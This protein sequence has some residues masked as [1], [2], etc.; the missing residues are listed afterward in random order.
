[1]PNPT[2]ERNASVKIAFGTENIDMMISCPKMF[3]M[4]S[5]K[6]MAKSLAP[7]VLEARMECG[8]A[9]ICDLHNRGNVSTAERA[10]LLFC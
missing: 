9:N 2:K 1:M 10:H 3:G 6:M 5:L 8:G 4:I 7:R